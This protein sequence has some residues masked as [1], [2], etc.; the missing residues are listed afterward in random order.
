MVFGCGFWFLVL[1]RVVFFLGFGLLFFHSETKWNH[2]PC[3]QQFLGCAKNM[4][5][6]LIQA[7]HPD[8]V[9]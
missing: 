1:V 2:F 5:T 7:Q 4:L 9:S 3:P 6:F 8:I